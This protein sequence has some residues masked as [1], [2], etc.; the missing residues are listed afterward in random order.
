MY[1]IRG[2]G[3]HTCY[4]FGSTLW[5]VKPQIVRQHLGVLTAGVKAGAWSGC[6]IWLPVKSRAKYCSCD[7]SMCVLTAQTRTN[8][9]NLGAL[10][11]SRKFSLLWHVH[12]HF[13]WAGSHKVYAAGSSSSGSAA[14]CKFSHIPA[15]A[16]SC[17]DPAKF[18]SKRS[19]HDPVQVLNWRSSGGPGEILPKRSLREELADAMSE[20]CLYESSYGR[21]VGCSCKKIL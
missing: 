16:N 15:L 14:H 6:S 8:R 4:W 18:L 5:C 2:F 19:L 13:N 10:H 7:I 12:V 3:L 17:G 1:Y 21:L 9:R 11:F 20:L